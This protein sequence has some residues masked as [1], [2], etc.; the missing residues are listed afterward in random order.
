[1]DAPSDKPKDVLETH[2]KNMSL[3]GEIR[4]NFISLINA[5]KNRQE[6]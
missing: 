4:R 3:A 6:D 2:N 5:I 1:M